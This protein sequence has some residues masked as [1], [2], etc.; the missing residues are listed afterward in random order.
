MAIRVNHEHEVNRRTLTEE[1]SDYLRRE[2]LLSDTWEQGSFLR[3]EDVADALKVS[4][5]P[6]REAEKH[7]NVRLVRFEDMLL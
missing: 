7:G 3:E 6:V 1:V 5:A 2:L 4:R